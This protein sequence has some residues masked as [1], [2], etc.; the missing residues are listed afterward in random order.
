MKYTMF[1]D[2][3]VLSIKEYAYAV[4]ISFFI[5]GLLGILTDIIFPKIPFN[6]FVGFLLFIAGAISLYFTYTNNL[7]FSIKFLQPFVI[8][9][10][11]LVLLAVPANH[12]L[13]S[14]LSI[15]FYLFLDGFAKL[16]FSQAIRPIPFWNY[17]S[18][19]GALSVV[20]ALS[21]L[22]GWEIMNS[23]LLAFLISVNILFD[24]L[25][26]FILSKKII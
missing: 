11:S 22:I 18:Y 13:I 24:G 2:K 17:I 16:I 7:K 14:L 23:W 20:L 9:T 3:D 5:I 6:L 10:S 26:L 21:I 19:S 8:L 12:E 15:L 1:D 4:G 25:M